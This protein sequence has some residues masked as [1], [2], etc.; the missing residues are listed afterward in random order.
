MLQGLKLRF[1]YATDPSAARFDPL[2][3]T[4]TFLNPAYREILTS[5][6]I[7]TAKEYLIRLCKPPE[8][9]ANTQDDDCTYVSDAD[10]QENHE[11]SPPSKRPKLLS[12]VASLIEAK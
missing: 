4:A 10:L 11:I 1:D 7:K 9:D 5:T 12:R 3:V 6:Q 8:L 2:F